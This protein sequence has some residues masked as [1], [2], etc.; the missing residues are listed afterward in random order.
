MITTQDVAYIAKLAHLKINEQ[1]QELFVGQLNTILDYV[2]Q[3]N[4][5][6]EI[7]DK[8]NV[9]PTMYTWS[10]ENSRLREDKA[11][12]SMDRE[13]ILKESADARKGSF[14]V[15]KVIEHS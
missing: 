10:S 3:L 11:Q 14:A 12:P 7:L 9:Q 1:E 2:E 4:E 8:E 15:P 5:L 6:D 13:D